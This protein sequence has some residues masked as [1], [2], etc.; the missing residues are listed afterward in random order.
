MMENNFSMCHAHNGL[1]REVDTHSKE[2]TS[3]FK[4]KRCFLEFPALLLKE[5]LYRM[6]METYVGMISVW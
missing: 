3:Y 6:G 4:S 5:T 2:N 1:F